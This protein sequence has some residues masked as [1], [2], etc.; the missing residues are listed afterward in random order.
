MI[1]EDGAYDISVLPDD[2]VCCR[3]YSELLWLICKNEILIY[4]NNNNCVLDNKNMNIN[5]ERVCNNCTEKNGIII[6]Y[7]LSSNNSIQ[8]ILYDKNKNEIKTKQISMKLPSNRILYMEIIKSTHL[9]LFIL[10]FTIHYYLINDNNNYINTHDYIFSE[11]GPTISQFNSTIPF[12]NFNSEYVIRYGNYNSNCSYIS[13]GLFGNKLLCQNEYDDVVLDD[14]SEDNK[15]ILFTSN[16]NNKKY[17]MITWYNENCTQSYSFNDKT[18]KHEEI[19][20]LINDSFTKYIHSDNRKNIIYQI[21]NDK[22]NI[23]DKDKSLQYN[24]P[25]S[26][27]HT[28]ISTDIVYI[29]GDKNILMLKYDSIELHEIYKSTMNYEV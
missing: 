9:I 2:L 28:L 16:Y 10:P 1:L 13:C 3:C 21:T 12:N 15:P 6:T 29:W 20:G 18:M 7:I 27:F 25:F 26:L 14:Y 11:P 19:N 22:V 24:I 17:V 8:Q 4:N 5:I 23:I